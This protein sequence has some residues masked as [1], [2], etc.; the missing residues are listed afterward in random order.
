MHFDFAPAE[1]WF[2]RLSFVG[3][4]L[5]RSICPEARG[6][7]LESSSDVS[8]FAGVKVGA[9]VGSWMWQGERPSK[10]A[11]E[12]FFAWIMEAGEQ[13]S[14]VLALRAHDARFPKFWL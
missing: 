11:N 3:V 7:C 2:T 5:R 8:G 13:G 4:V 1:V 10:R 14:C 12:I 6:K 9:R